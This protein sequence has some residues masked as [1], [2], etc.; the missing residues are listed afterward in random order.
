[1]YR[2]TDLSASKRI[3]QLEVDGLLYDFPLLKTIEFRYLPG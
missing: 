3:Y 2:L 1:L